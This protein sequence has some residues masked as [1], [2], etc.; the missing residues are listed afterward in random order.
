MTINSYIQAVLSVHG[1]KNATEMMNVIELF[2]AVKL[3]FLLFLLH[4]HH[5]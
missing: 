1:N 2:L 3:L 4:H 5:C